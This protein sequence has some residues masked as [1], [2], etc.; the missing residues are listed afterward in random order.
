MWNKRKIGGWWVVSTLMI[1]GGAGALACS[2]FAQVGPNP[3]HVLRRAAARATTL[4]SS[5]GTMALV[6]QYAQIWRK[7]VRQPLDGTSAT[8]PEGSA[9]LFTSAVPATS[10]V[11]NFKLL[12]TAVD[13]VRP[14]AIFSSD[15]Q[16]YPQ[17]CTVGQTIGGMTIVAIEQQKV[18]VQY[19][20]Q[21]LELTMP[22]QSDVA[23]DGSPAVAN[24]PAPA[25]PPAPAYLPE[26]VY[27]ATTAPSR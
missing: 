10:A 3:L 14:C 9:V 1:A 8:A 16:D 22:E 12:G 13:A 23:V 4:P 27:P 2:L 20:G 17:V 18:T 26:R 11:P 15:S 19:Q 5:V 25:N 24:L 21:K 7:D 6:E